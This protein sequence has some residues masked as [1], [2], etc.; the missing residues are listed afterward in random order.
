MGRTERTVEYHTWS[1]T[2][3]ATDWILP[4]YKHSTL[5]IMHTW[6]RY[7]YICGNW[8]TDPPSAHAMYRVSM[9]RKPIFKCKLSQISAVLKTGTGRNLCTGTSV[10]GKSRKVQEVNACIHYIH[11]IHVLYIAIVAQPHSLWKQLGGETRAMHKY[12]RHLVVL[13]GHTHCYM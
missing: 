8:R 10:Q 4:Y 12:P 1:C 11:S 3:P 6:C 9:K 2:Q 5:G 13:G 7:M